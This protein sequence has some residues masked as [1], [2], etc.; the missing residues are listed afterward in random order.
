MIPCI[1]NQYREK[2]VFWVHVKLFSFTR[3]TSALKSIWLPV[4]ASVKGLIPFLR[5]HPNGISKYP[6][7]VC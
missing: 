2:N 3:T 4:Q 5:Y 6:Q 1:I 7:T